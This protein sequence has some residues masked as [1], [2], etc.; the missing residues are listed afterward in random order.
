MPPQGIAMALVD[1]IILACTAA[2]PASCRD[3]H[4]V[5]EWGGSLRSCTLAAEPRLEQ[6]SEAHPNLQIQRWHCAWPAREDEKS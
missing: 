3:Y 1:L 4:I 5:F 2:H 6:W